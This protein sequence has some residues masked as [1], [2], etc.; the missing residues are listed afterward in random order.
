MKAFRCGFLVVFI[1]LFYKCED[2]FLLEL[3]DLTYVDD[4]KLS[5][6][7]SVLNQHRTGK[8]YI[9]KTQWFTTIAFLFKF[10]GKTPPLI[11]R[12]KQSYIEEVPKYKK[13]ALVRTLRFIWNRL[14][15]NTEIV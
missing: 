1:E 5:M 6:F 14:R 12:Q 8:R 3:C 10:R 15:S 13:K 2:P 7:Y 4:I 11:I 9:S